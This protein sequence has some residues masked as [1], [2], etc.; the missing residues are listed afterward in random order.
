MLL[1]VVGFA[2]FFAAFKKVLSKQPRTDDSAVHSKVMN[3]HRLKTKKKIDIARC[4]ETD[5]NFMSSRD[6]KTFQQN[7]N[8]LGFNI[9]GNVSDKVKQHFEEFQSGSGSDNLDLL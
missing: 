2:V 9:I 1:F 3:G 4:C 5:T 6:Q 7:W 8:E